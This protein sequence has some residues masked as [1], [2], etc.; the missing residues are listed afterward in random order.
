MSRPASKRD[1]FYWFMAGYTFLHL[2]W[3]VVLIYDFLSAPLAPDSTLGSTPYRLFIVL[4]VTPLSLVVSIL[5][6]RRTPGNVTGFCLLLWSVHNGLAVP[7]TS[8]FFIYN[9]AFNTGWTGLWLLALYFPNGRAAPLRFERWIRLLSVGTI[10]MVSVWYFFQPMVKNF[11]A[12]NPNEVVIA[13]PFFIPALG[14]LQSVVNVFEGIFL[15]STILLIVPSILL[16]YRASGPTERQQIKWLGWTYGLL[17]A[18]LPFYIYTGLISGSPYKYGIPG[19]V[20]FLAF[21]VYISLAPYISV[22]NAILR[23]HLYDIDIVIRR[24]LVY[25]LLSALL[26]L[27]FFGGVTLL[28]RLF[29]VFS[30][31]QSTLSIVISTLAIAALFTPLRR[32]I[33]EFID[34]RFYRQK[35]NAEQ[36]LAEFAAAARSQ[37]D[38]INLTDHL[39]HTVRSTIQPDSLSLWLIQTSK[40]KK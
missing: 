23:H 7:S 31:Q 26:G 13:N 22:G 12:G 21:G 32:R 34:R 30:S 38:L 40:E 3:M 24:T 19:L 14:P 9:G 8:P 5:V 29:S 15:F 25:S 4:V 17:I 6:L 37:T 10:L 36:A 35:Y 33:Q 27:V 28:Q 11:N 39:A 20:A 2:A 18:S 16:R 1:W